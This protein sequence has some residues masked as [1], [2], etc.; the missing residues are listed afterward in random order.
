MA[1]LMFAVR[2]RAWSRHVT[3]NTKKKQILRLL[4]YP[5]GEAK[6]RQFFV[7]NHDQWCSVQQRLP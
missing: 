5:C 4:W 7:R 6:L 2:A 1:S 3:P